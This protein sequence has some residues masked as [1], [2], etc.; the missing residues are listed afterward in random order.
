[1][2]AKLERRKTRKV[3]IDTVDK[4]K[5]FVQQTSKFKGSIDITSGRYAIDGRSLMGILSLDL[6]R[7]VEVCYTEDDAELAD[8]SLSK[9][10]VEGGK[11]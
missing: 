8:V 5:D 1:M 9:Y 6:S 7:P 2:K 4:V 11:G 10:F 3:L